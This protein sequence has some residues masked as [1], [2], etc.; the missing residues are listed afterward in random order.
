MK[1]LGIV[2]LLF[3]HCAFSQKASQDIFSKISEADLYNR[4]Y[5]I[6]ATAPAVVL[7]DVGKTE[8]INNGK[9]WFRFEFNRHK[10]I[11][12]LN[13][14]AYDLANVG[15]H[16]YAEG[17]N[18]ERLLSVKATTY[19]LENGRI[20][21]TKLDK[22]SVY[23]VRVNKNNIL[24]RF[25]L[26]AVKEGSIID[27]EYSIRSD[28][29]FNLTPWIFQNEVPVLWSEYR[30]ALPEF[31]GYIFL[32]QGFHSYFINE[33]NDRVT[34]FR[35]SDDRGTG[36]AQGL[37]FT[38]T[39]TDYRWV[40]KDIP[41][42]KKENL[43]SSPGNY[44]SKI[45]F[46]L[47]G[48][49]YPLSEKEIM[50]GW[51]E[52]VGQL[53]EREDFGKDLSENET[54]IRPLM[55]SIAKDTTN[56]LDLAKNIYAYIRDNFVCTDYDA[57][58]TTQ[59][60][61]NVAKAKKGNVAEL[62]LLLTALLTN[63]GVAAAPIILSTRDNGFAYKEYAVLDRFNYVVCRA[64]IDGKIYFLDA[65][66]PLLGFGKLPYECFN[67]WA[68]V[69]DTAAT[70]V[71]LNP[72][73][74]KEKKLTSLVLAAN[75]HEWMGSFIQ[76]LGDYQSHDLRTQV[77]KRGGDGYFE[78]LRESFGST[79]KTELGKID[80]LKL[81]D[82]P[83]KVEYQ[84]AKPIETGDFI[85]IHPLFSEAKQNPFNADS[86]T[87]PVEMPYTIDET[88]LATIYIPQR[89]T[90]ESLPK[91]IKVKLNED[92]ES[93]FEYAIEQQGNMILLRSVI[94]LDR[95]YYAPAEYDL[96]RRFFGMIAGKHKEG[97]VLKRTN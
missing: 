25:T 67:G 45:D 54:W 76:Q 1:Q 7:A 42:L 27:I 21:E 52:M 11:H 41:A 63:K 58:Y 13:S 97:I 57:L 56:H 19:N 48:Y 77:K 68:R 39:I 28:Y 46:Q 74:L 95:A 92:E 47:S 4:T 40:M 71:D 22:N 24:K 44:I 20:K 64:E 85:Y 29:L 78:N 93:Y 35:V 16:L 91:S 26:P 79:T 65:S 72:D 2:L 31:L 49:R 66:R 82:Q 61:K 10:R 12:I 18:S 73:L 32:R 88:Y 81:Y 36:T 62:N 53:L 5:T 55:K 34:N 87:Y 23:T 96:L 9:N 80:S 8:I 59:S 70:A 3:T 89:Y 33:K 60:L 43:V 75:E 6:D 38:A 84:F 30:L 37:N 15:I 83:V 14:A 90:V 69:I 50:P 51:E 86:R 17:E 94:K